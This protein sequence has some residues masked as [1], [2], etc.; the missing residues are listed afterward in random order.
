[1]VYSYNSIK[2]ISIK[3]LVFFLFA[4][5]SIVFLLLSCELKSDNTSN[6]S[7]IKDKPIALFQKELLN[8]AFNTATS[9]PVH[10]HIKDRSRAQEDVVSA[11]LKLD[12]PNLV[13]GYIEKIDD[14]RRGDC[15]ADLAFYCVR[16]GQRD[17]VQ[18]YLDIAK[19]IADNENSQDWRK[20]TIKVK[21]AKTYSLLGDSKRADVYEA[22][23]VESETGKV[24]AV[25]AATSDAA[26]F[27]E[28][29]KAL[30]ELVAKG[31]FDITRN[32][33]DAYIQL[34]D[35]FYTDPNLRWVAEEKLK[36]SF[37]KVPVFIHI[38]LLEKLA[39]IALDHKD[40]VKALALVNEA[41]DLVVNHQWQLEFRIP[42]EAKLIELRFRAG[43]KQKAQNDAAALRDLY[44]A[45]GKKIVD[46]YRAKTIR[47]LAEAYKSMDDT[48]AA[49]SIYK[50]AIEEGTANPNSRP[51][52]ED[53]SATCCSMALSAVEPDAELWNRINHISGALG[54]PW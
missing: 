35:R 11:C 26:S 18:K 49:L 16:H 50:L 29:L 51:R 3:T 31:N 14:W 37:N 21:I 27:D 46:I 44:N 43:N 28:C 9:I 12:Q 33:L 42:I 7:I 22:N 52:A 45:E 34:F 8:I 41:Q 6:T 40:K 54:E 4:T 20:D 47:P 23:V 13:P 25:K 24:E 36:A 2:R 32:A 10:P 15:Y 19:Q 48:K 17:N 1:M 30:G 38:E 53:L 39:G 5:G